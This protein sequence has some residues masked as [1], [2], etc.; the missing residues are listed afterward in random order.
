[1]SA[2]VSAVIVAYGNAD[3]IA[4]LVR[5]VRTSDVVGEVVVIDHGDD[6]AADQ[7]EEAGAIVAR[8]PSNP[9]FGAGQ[10][11]GR[12]L[13]GGVYVLMLNPD[14]E[15]VSGA[16]DVGV[17][18]LES[19]PEVGAVQGIIENVDTGSPE[20]SS[21]EELGW[22]HLVGRAL[23]ARRL[24][25]IHWLAAILARGTRFRDHVERVPSQPTSVEALAATAVLARRSVLDA[26]GGFDEQYFLYGEDLDL[27]RRM[28]SSGCDLVTLPV[29]WARHESGGSSEGWWARERWWWEGTMRYAAINWDNA[30]FA[31]ALIAAAL[32][33]IRMLVHQ[34]SGWS[35]AASSLLRQPLKVRRQRANSLN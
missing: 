1:M 22:L 6:G 11:R 19:H 24:L 21:G 23:G 25:S 30:A 34:P 20:R 3:V 26:I 32:Q 13:S 17:E 29:P 15:I 10:N 7:A 16:L 14:A 27:C 18:Y 12:L 5:N 2:P 33:W 9:G 28:R 4:E 35:V 8:D 31:G